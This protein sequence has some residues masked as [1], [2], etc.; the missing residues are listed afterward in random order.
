MERWRAVDPTNCPVLLPVFDLANHN[1]E[2]KVLWTWG[3]K[4]CT[5]TVEEDIEGGKEI[6]NNYGPKSNEECE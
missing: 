6:Y 3:A 1:P 2:A 5:L 4:Y